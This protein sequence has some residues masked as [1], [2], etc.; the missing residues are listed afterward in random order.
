M[1]TPDFS[2]FS[3][4]IAEDDEANFR[5]YKSML[6][7]TG[8][9]VIHADNGEDAVNLFKDNKVDLV[10]M[11]AMMPG[12]DG[13]IATKEIRNISEEVPVI[14]LTAYAN[15]DSIREAVKSGCTDYL[16]KPVSTEVL[17][18]ALKKWLTGFN[19]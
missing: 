18:S 8:I 16:S 7:K 3:V 9:K 13:F 11:D 5:L 10:I 19:N 15:Q 1:I 17:I 2:S 14:M 6:K 4:L 12:K